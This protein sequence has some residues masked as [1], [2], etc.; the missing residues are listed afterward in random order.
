MQPHMILICRKT[1]RLPVSNRYWMTYWV[2]CG[3]QQPMPARM[4]CGQGGKLIWAGGGLC[5]PQLNQDVIQSLFE[6]GNRMVLRQIKIICGCIDE[7]AAVLRLDIIQKTWA[8]CE[9]TAQ[10]QVI[11]D[12]KT[13]MIRK[14]HDAVLRIELQCSKCGR[15]R[16]HRVPYGV[17]VGA[18]CPETVA[19]FNC[20]VIQIV[21]V[22]IVG[23]NDIVHNPHAIAAKS[24]YGKPYGLVV[25]HQQVSFHA[26]V[27]GAVPQ[28]NAA[29]VAE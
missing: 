22:R 19:E 26:H 16:L 3:L 1:I 14:D 6:T 4:W 10:I 2:S 7:P 27:K 23:N 24:L 5:K 13:V 17:M 25:V 18:A 8:T 29:R 15:F 11:F 21:R 28:Q 9:A 20:I 12:G